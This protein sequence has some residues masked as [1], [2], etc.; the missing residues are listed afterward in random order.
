MSRRN[1]GK[2]PSIEDLED[3]IQR[4]PE[5]VYASVGEV[6]RLEEAGDPGVHKA[7]AASWI[8][9]AAS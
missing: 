9:R 4:Y 6:E 1:P 2:F 3:A 8:T 7:Y 5:P